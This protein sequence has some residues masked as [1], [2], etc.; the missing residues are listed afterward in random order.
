MEK[1]FELDRGGKTIRGIA[2]IPDAPGRCPA[3]VYCHGFTSDSNGPQRLFV[4]AAR[5]FEGCSIAGFRF[6]CTGS[7]GSDGNFEDMTLTGE[8]EDLGAVY[9]YAVSQPY[10][11]PERTALLGHSMGGPAVIEANCLLGGPV[12]LNIL[13]SSAETLYHELISVLTG[14]RLERFMREGLVDFGGYTVGKKLTDELCMKNFYSDALKMSGHT[15]L[16]HGKCD[17][18]SPVYNS[19]KLAELLG[20]R[21][22]L[23]LIDGADH[24]FTSPVYQ[25]EVISEIKRFMLGA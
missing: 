8:A 7:G 21:A 3:V 11:D 12:K 25:R 17:G 13:L 16:V 1:Y 10:V 23:R 15:L 22:Q 2:H 20:E 19:V 4:K 18:E 9:E 24:S 14:D 5:E 6:D